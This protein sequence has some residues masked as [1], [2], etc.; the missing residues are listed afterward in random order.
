MAK[1]RTKDFIDFIYFMAYKFRIIERR[2]LNPSP[3]PSP[4][5]DP[6]PSDACNREMERLEVAVNNWKTIPNWTND[7]GIQVKNHLDVISPKPIC[8]M[9]QEEF[10]KQLDILLDLKRATLKHCLSRIDL[11]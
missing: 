7:Y 8:E 4:S 1:D 10:D 5:P 2:G 6:S 11:G 9:S 3:S